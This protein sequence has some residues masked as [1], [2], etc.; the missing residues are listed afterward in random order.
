M[1]GRSGLCETIFND[2]GGSCGSFAGQTEGKKTVHKGINRKPSR[3]YASDFSLRNGRIFLMCIV[4]ASPQIGRNFLPS[5]KASSAF[6]GGFVSPPLSS[7]SF[8]D[9]RKEG[10]RKSRRPRAMP[11]LPWYERIR[12]SGRK[13]FC[14]DGGV[15]V[16]AQMKI[17]RCDSSGHIGV[18]ID[19]CP[20]DQKLF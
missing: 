4:Y 15:T 1:R 9:E 8:L 7:F 12:V 16:K 18:T 20:Q 13:I 11:T 3:L 10:K 6:S 5:A 17:P 19:H 2:S 14:L